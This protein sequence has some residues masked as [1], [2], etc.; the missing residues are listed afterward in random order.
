MDDIIYSLKI[1]SLTAA[2]KPSSDAA[3][4]VVCGREF[5]SF[6]VVGKKENL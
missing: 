6:M 4:T 5:Q 1:L 2:L 3:V